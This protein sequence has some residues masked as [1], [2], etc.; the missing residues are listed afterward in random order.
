MKKYF[1][2]KKL[3]ELVNPHDLHDVLGS[4]MENGLVEEYTCEY[5]Q[6]TIEIVIP[7]SVEIRE[8]MA[9]FQAVVESGRKGN[10]H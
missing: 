8:L 9:G 2:V 5:N 4:L 7:K 6:D 3:E 10:V 1:S